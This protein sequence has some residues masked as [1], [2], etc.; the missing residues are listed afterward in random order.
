MYIMILFH[1]ILSVSFEIMKF[2]QAYEFRNNTY[3]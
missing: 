3:F 2:K 1:D